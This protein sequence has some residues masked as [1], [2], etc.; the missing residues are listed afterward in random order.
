MWFTL[1]YEKKNKFS[2]FINLIHFIYIKVSK[3]EN[4]RRKGTVKKTNWNYML[5]KA[6]S[7][8]HEEELSDKGSL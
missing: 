8:N 4:N 5:K 6:V 3:N 1:N 7:K 2:K